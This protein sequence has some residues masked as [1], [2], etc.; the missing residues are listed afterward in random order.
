M[1]G[2]IVLLR[3]EG[4]IHRLHTTC[5]LVT[6]VLAHSLAPLSARGGF[7]EVE[8]EGWSPPLHYMMYAVT[9]GQKQGNRANELEL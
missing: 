4:E 8:E 3:E 1:D 7:R 6:C 9:D 5:Y 2:R